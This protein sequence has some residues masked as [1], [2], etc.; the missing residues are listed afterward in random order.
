LQYSLDLVM[1]AKNINQIIIKAI[2]KTHSIFVFSESRNP[3]ALIISLIDEFIAL[4]E[5]DDIRSAKL[6]ILIFFAISYFNEYNVALRLIEVKSL[7]VSGSYL[8]VLKEFYTGLLSLFIAKSSSEKS[9]LIS[10]ANGCITQL[11]KWSK[12]SPH[13]ILNKLM[14]LEAELSAINGDEDLAIQSYEKAIL[15]S[16]RYNFIHEEALACE[17]SGIYFL[18]RNNERDA[19]RRL[20][21]SYQAY[22]HWG[23][24]AKLHHLRTSHP[25]LLS[26]FNS[27][28][29]SNSRSTDIPSDI[30]CP[31]SVSSASQVSELY[32]NSSVVSGNDTKKR[33]HRYMD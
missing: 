13:N 12:T 9:K 4:N 18:E 29:S 5:T 19:S 33:K 7:F 17:K 25:S 20:V 8:H 6:G 22:F 24:T 11:R 1:N 2:Q 26:L 15:L 27:I 31:S 32:G 30:M 14:L 10:T 28:Y 21:Q 23:A 16:K 3:S